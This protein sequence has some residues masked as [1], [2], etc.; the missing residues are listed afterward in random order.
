MGPPPPPPP[1]PPPAIHGT[2]NEEEDPVLQVVTQR[3]ITRG[4]LLDNQFCVSLRHP[5][6]FK[7]YQDADDNNGPLI[8]TSEVD[9]NGP[10]AAAGLLVGDVLV[11][12]QDTCVVYQNLKFSYI[13][14]IASAP[15]VVKLRFVRPRKDDDDGMDALLTMPS[16]DAGTREGKPWHPFNGGAL[17]LTCVF[18]ST[19][20][21]V[22][23]RLS[24]FAVSQ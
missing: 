15:D 23:R 3:L 24:I 20:M 13:R 21:I 7:L 11:S 19:P 6:G 12:V 10:A 17:S 14:I 2:S 22:R 8:R 4:L 9:P 18:G 5:L 1:L 16:Q